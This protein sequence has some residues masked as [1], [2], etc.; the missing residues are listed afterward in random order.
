MN[1]LYGKNRK[2][3]DELFRI[4]QFDLGFGKYDAERALCE[5][6][7]GMV[8]SEDKILCYDGKKIAIIATQGEWLL[9]QDSFFNKHGESRPDLV[10]VV[11]DQMVSLGRRLG[12][13]VIMVINGN[14]LERFLKPSVYKSNCYIFMGDVAENAGQCVQKKTYVRS[15]DMQSASQQVNMTVLPIK[16]VDGPTPELP[17]ARVLRECI[18]VMIKKGADYQSKSST[19]RQADYYPNGIATILDIVH[20]KCLRLR[21]VIEATQ[22]GG[23][24]NFE[25]IEDSAKDAINYL[26]FLCAYTRGEID[27]QN[28]NNDAFNR[29]KVIS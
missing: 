28:P 16:S 27:G 11:R 25:S 21:S 9:I 20:A 8:F 29:P 14:T 5:L 13:H 10:I 6:I 2:L 23:K 7:K 26:A 3:I 22:A 12:V 24:P 15:Q 1:D 17:S 19:V 4:G 18:E